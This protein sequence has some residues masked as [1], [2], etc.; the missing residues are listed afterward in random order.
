MGNQVIFRSISFWRAVKKSG[1]N[2]SP[3]IADETVA[4]DA[5]LFD[6]RVREVRRIFCKNEDTRKPGC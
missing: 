1:C 3:G 6:Y 4:D 5:G 2:G